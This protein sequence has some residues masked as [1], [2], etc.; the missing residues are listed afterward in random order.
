[1][2]SFL[3]DIRAVVAIKDNNKG[4]KVEF[5]KIGDVPDYIFT[6]ELRLRQVLT[7]ILG[8][9]VKFTENGSVLMAYEVRN[10]RLIFTITDTGMGIAP[11][12]VPL[13]F[14]PFSQVDGSVSRKHEGTGLGLLLSRRL[15]EMLGGNVVLKSSS[16]EQG[17]TFEVSIAVE[18]P[19]RQTFLPSKF[20]VRDTSTF[21][22]LKNRSILVV[23]DVEDNLLLIERML[24]KR[25]ADVTLATNGEEAL[26]LALHK[27]FDIILMDIQMPVMD[28][29]SATRKL[30]A[31]G[32]Q[33]PIIALTANA[34][35]DD[36]D[37]C[38]EAGCSEYLTKPLQAEKL[39]QLLV[40]YSKGRPEPEPSPSL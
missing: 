4:L 29:Y 28:G 34:M 1:L 8:N 13:L 2:A 14:Q 27:K 18:N 25:G 6:D 24:T 11:E 7:N 20:P 21:T 33:N 9:A 17:S 38:I 16:T 32:Y 39:V 12:K 40:A 22:P 26:N 23:D 36:R 30:R 19:P 10:K 5:R 37:R 15:A 3:E 31:A 35:K